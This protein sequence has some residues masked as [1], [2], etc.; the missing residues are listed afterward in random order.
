M[1]KLRAYALAGLVGAIAMPGYAEDV[2]TSAWNESQW[3]AVAEEC[4][5]AIAADDLS[6]VSEIAVL[7]SGMRREIYGRPLK[8]DGAACLGAA[9]N[10]EWKYLVEAGRFLTSA[11]AAAQIQMMDIRRQ[12]GAEVERLTKAVADAGRSLEESKKQTDDAL[13]KL[14]QEVSA[15][16]ARA[17]QIRTLAACDALLVADE[18][19]ALTSSVCHSLFV[20]NGM[21]DSR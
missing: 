20:A 21:L 7:L 9:S 5:T 19:A 2:D 15:A 16:R 17:V 11:G 10:K 18:I 13:A 3:T 8:E 12:H 6:R 14:G 4:R 1:T